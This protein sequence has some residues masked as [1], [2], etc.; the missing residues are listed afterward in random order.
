MRAI[1]DF[2][3]ANPLIAL[4]LAILAIVLI[5][6]IFKKLFKIA[7][8]IAI[9]LLLGGGTVYHFARKQ[10]DT[11]GRELLHKGKELLRA[12]TEKVEETIT[13]ESRTLS[14]KDSSTRNGSHITRRK[15]RVKPA[16]T[17]APEE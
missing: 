1:S 4:A 10:F 14:A 6:S 2:L 17:R 7:I 8:I 9:I 5:F 12:G 3:S 13:G 16:A 15:A 11:R